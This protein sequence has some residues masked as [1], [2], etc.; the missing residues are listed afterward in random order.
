MEKHDETK[1]SSG[2]SASAE[3]ERRVWDKS[4]FAQ[5]GEAEELIEEAVVD[6]YGEE[7]QAGGFFT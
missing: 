4:P 3:A 2:G 7:E 1:Q 5:Q 6:A